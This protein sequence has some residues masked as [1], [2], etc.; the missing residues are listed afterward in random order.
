MDIDIS[1]NLGI[2]MRP[3]FSFIHYR[4]SYS[5]S[6]VITQ[7]RMAKKNSFQARVECVRKNPGE[8]LKFHCKPLHTERLTTESARV[9]LVEVRARGTKITPHF[10]EWRELRSLVPMVGQQISRR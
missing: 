8:Q 9:Y 10:V 4:D 6:K 7:K 2:N 3:A 1:E 5:T